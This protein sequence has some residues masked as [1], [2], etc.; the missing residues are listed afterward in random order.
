MMLTI[1]DLRPRQPAVARACRYPAYTT[2]VMNAHVSFGSQPQYRPHALFAHSAPAMTA[3]VQIGNAM[4]VAHIAMRSNVAAD[5]SR[6]MMPRDGVGAAGASSSDSRWSAVNPA[7]SANVSE[8]TYAAPT[9]LPENDD[10]MRRSCRSFT[11]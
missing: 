9:V 2:H 6:A 4:D 10:P 1:A 5:G 11:R 8:P 3:K 7:L